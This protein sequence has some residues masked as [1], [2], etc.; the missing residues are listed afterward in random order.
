MVETPIARTR[1]LPGL[2]HDPVA[3][4]LPP[5]SQPVLGSPVLMEVQRRLA[6]GGATAGLLLDVSHTLVG[7]EHL[8]R[9]ET[10]GQL[11][12][13]FAD[14]LEPFTGWIRQIHVSAPAGIAGTGLEDRHQPIG[15]SL[16][17]GL[18]LT[19]LRQMHTAFRAGRRDRVLVCTIRSTPA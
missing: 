11:L 13:L 7:L 16:T 4:L 19:A 12:E 1:H 9:P 14:W 3:P 10:E 18:L 6:V 8:Y 2:L 15:E 17:R 5:D